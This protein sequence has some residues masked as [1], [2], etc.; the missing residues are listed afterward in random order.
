MIESNYYL[1]FL[2]YAFQSGFK[3]SVFDYKLFHKNNITPSDLVFK[4]DNSPIK[5]NFPETGKLLNGLTENIPF[6]EF[7]KRS[8][9]LA[10]I[11]IKDDKIIYENYQ[12]GYNGSSLFQVFSIS[13]SF[14]SALVGSA[15]EEKFLDSIDDPV[16][17]YLP[18]LKSNGLEKITVNN[19]VQ[20]HSGIKFTEGFCPWKEMVKSY[21]YPNGRKLSKKMVVTDEI[22]KFFHYS[23]YHLILLTMI[24]ERILPVTPT[25]Y[26]E[27]KIWKKIGTEFPAQ[28]CLDNSQ[29]GMEKLESGFVC[30]PIDLAKF[31]RLYIKNGISNGEQIVPSTWILNSTNFTETNSQS[32]YFDY[33]K[34]KSWGPWFRSG[35]AAYKNYWWGY[36]IDDSYFE[37]FAMGIMGQILYVSPQNNAIGIRIGNA[38]GIN[39]WWPSLIKDIIHNL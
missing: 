25:K 12:P 35:K 36:K 2:S 22:G 9:T 20:M 5:I 19:L 3:Q 28:L 33:Y 1:R 8:R 17:K 29:N 4:F 30:S 11:I 6:E 38:W 10:F 21:L 13:K 23:D 26:F 14:T 7:L 15:L 34:D 37:Y 31:G 18:E 27:E 32:N 16:T 24:L 39:G